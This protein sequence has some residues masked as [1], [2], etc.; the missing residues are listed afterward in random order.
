[1]KDFYYIP[2]FN[3]GKEVTTSDWITILIIIAI[4]VILLIFLMR[5]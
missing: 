1:M 3:S 4:T 2:I 5:D